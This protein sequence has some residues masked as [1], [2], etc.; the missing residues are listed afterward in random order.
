MVYGFIYFPCMCLS[1][2]FLEVSSRTSSSPNAGW[3][4][5]NVEMTTIVVI[6]DIDVTYCVM[7]KYLLL[8]CVVQRG[9]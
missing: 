1:P 7:Q 8:R 4:E 2:R 9:A 5:L 3:M 6:F